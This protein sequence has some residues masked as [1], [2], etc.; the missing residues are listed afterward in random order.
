LSLVND[1]RFAG[2]FLLAT[3]RTS[4]PRRATI[5]FPSRSLMFFETLYCFFIGDPRRKR[6]PLV[7]DN[8]CCGYLTV[9]TSAWKVPPEL[10]KMVNHWK[11]T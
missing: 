5:S 8:D 4:V 7:I 9:L 2:R 1:F 6:Y 3:Y 11:K 10:E